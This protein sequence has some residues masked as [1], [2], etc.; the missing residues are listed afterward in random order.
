MFTSS[1]VL[2][3]VVD[4]YNKSKYKE[5][6]SSD[7]VETYSSF[8][9]ILIVLAIILFAIEMF[10]LYRAVA[11]VFACTQKGFN[12]TMNFVLAILFPLPYLIFNVLFGNCD[13]SRL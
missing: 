3:N 8:Y 10:I 9:G 7:G 13:T 11:I 12:R 1:F 5:K 4:K 2:K 6:Y